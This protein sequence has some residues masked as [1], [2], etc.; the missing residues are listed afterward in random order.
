MAVADY[1]YGCGCLIIRL[2]KIPQGI[3]GKSM[4]VTEMGFE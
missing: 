1:D 3:K 4:L 2:E